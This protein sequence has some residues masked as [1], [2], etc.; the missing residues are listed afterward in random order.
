MS[1]DVVVERLAHLLHAV[2]PGEDGHRDRHLGLEAVLPLDVASHQQV[3]FLV[4]PSQLDVGPDG[5]GI[6]RLGERVEEFVDADRF[7]RL[8]PAFEI[9][10]LEHACHGVLAASWMT[11]AKLI[12]P[13]H[14]ELYSIWILFVE[15]ILVACSK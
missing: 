5:D 4:R 12:F 7:S 14:S 2:G 1:P 3:E 9:V 10:P 11:S 6:H 8:V 13:S 15:R